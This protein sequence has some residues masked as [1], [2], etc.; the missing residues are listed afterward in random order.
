MGMIGKRLKTLTHSLLSTWSETGDASKRWLCL[1][2]P[3]GQT[4]AGT[5]SYIII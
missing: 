1:H 5:Y 2:N 4:E 3:D